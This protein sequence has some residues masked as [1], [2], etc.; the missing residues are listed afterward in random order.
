MNKELLSVMIL[1][2]EYLVRELLKRSIDWEELGLAIVGEA[3]GTMEALDLVEEVHPDIIFADI[4]IPVMDGMEFSKRVLARYPQTKIIILTGHDEFEYAKESV[5]IGITDFLLKPV[6]AEEIGKVLTGVCRKVKEEKIFESEYRRLRGQIEDSF[7]YLKEKFYNDL[8]FGS[9]SEGEIEKKLIY[10]DI[11]FKFQNFQVAVIEPSYTSLSGKKNEEELLMLRMHCLE[12]I[13]KYFNDR[14]HL[15]AFF[16]LRGNIVLLK[17]NPDLKISEYCEVIKNNL[18]NRLSCSVC[19]GIGKEVNSLVGVSRSYEEARIALEYKIVEGKNN[20]ILFSDMNL[21]ERKDGIVLTEHL[22]DLGFFLRA[23]VCEKSSAIIKLIMNNHLGSSVDIESVRVSAANII[24]VILNI[25]MEVKIKSQ[26]VFRL[27]RQPYD[28]VYRIETIPEMISYLNNLVD[29]LVSSI[30]T[31]QSKC[32]SKMVNEVIEYLRENY[33]NSELTQNVVS[34][35]FNMNSSYLSR[36][37][38]QET[39]QTFIDY[40]SRIRIEKAI[41]FFKT[42]DKKNY[43]IA[44]EVGIADPHYFSIFFKKHMNMSISDYRKEIVK[45]NS[46]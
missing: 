39:G 16:G 3:S 7:S 46:D 20:V 32:T 12:I 31:I 27:G 2:D 36:K 6:N 1:D 44:E 17:N 21:S 24:S 43:E 37:F 25:I 40:L 13:R 5:K 19:I 29:L 22:V 35:E 4:C 34:G 26:D 10:Y 42:T 38:K 15:R 45:I 18:M 33:H 14:E 23:G 11:N 28:Y 30:N 41:D 9:L 8:L